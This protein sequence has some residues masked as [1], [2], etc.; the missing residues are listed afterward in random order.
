MSIKLN[1]AGAGITLI[2]LC[3][4]P[5]SASAITAEVAHAC[6]AL[7]AKSFPPREVGNPAAGSAKGTAQDQRA[8][9]EKC[10]ANGGKMDSEPAKDTK[11]K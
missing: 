6:D 1:F 10:V 5:P 11:S 8:F 7:V 9:F 2:C 4:M 3:A